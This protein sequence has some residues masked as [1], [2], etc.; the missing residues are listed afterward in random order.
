M[1]HADGTEHPRT[2]NIADVL[3]A[4]R[5]RLPAPLGPRIRADQRL[6]P[7]RRAAVR[8]GV[9]AEARGVRRMIVVEGLRPVV[10]S[11]GAGVFAGAGARLV[12]RAMFAG[13][14]LSAMDPLG[15][16]F[17]AVTPTAAGF[18]ACDM[19]ARRAS[20]VDPNVALRDL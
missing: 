12:I 18:V 3:A 5:G 10:W 9:D 4:K 15:F 1:L 14:N 7:T 17:A 13:S 8:P 11:V 19:P 16:G 20:R 6:G 2:H